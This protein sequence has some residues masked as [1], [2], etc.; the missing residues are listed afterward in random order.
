MGNLLWRG[1]FANVRYIVVPVRPLPPGLLTHRH[2]T[3]GAEPDPIAAAAAD[4]ALA[5]WV[6]TA[7]VSLDACLVVDAGGT[8]AAL[9]DTAAELLGTAPA[10]LVGRSLDKV[11]NLVDFTDGA[12]EAQGAA[13]RIPPLIA[14]A[15]N[16][17]SRGMMRIRL[18]DGERRMLDAVAAPIHDDERRPVGAV[19]FLASV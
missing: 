8:V 12:Q 15:E 6:E 14:V 13:R 11:L 19:S 7:R 2:V 16:A 17:L 18:P 9:S 10:G 3:G 5:C 1:G 4:D